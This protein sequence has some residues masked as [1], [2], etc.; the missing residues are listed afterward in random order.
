MILSNAK[1]GWVGTEPAV[2]VNVVD[3]EAAAAAKVE[4]EGCWGIALEDRTA[5]VVGATGEAALDMVSG[6]RATGMA[7]D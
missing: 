7:V 6:V 2:V 5:E 4:M 1:R 3:M